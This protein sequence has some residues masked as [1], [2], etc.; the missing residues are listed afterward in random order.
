M[1]AASTENGRKSAGFDSSGCKKKL[2]DLA[3]GEHGMLTDLTEGSCESNSLVGRCCI[4]TASAA[5]GCCLPTVFAGDN[6]LPTAN[7]GGGCAPMVCTKS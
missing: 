5:G 1:A 6:C 2:N 3:F 7:I 4:Y